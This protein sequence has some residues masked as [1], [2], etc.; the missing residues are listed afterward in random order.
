[1]DLQVAPGVFS[2]GVDAPD[3]KFF[4]NQYLLPHGMSYNSYVVVAG[5]IAVMDSV[6]A[7]QGDRWMSRIEEAVGERCP[8][9]LVV[10]HMEPDHS[11]CILEAMRRWPEM[12]VVATAKAIAMM[13]QFFPDAASDMTSRCL[14][15]KEGDTLDLDGCTLRF[16]LA[17]MVHWPEVMVTY[18]ETH[19]ILFSADAFG[20]FG[21]LEHTDNWIDEARR[22]Y[23]NIVNKYGAQV[24][25]VLKKLSP[26]AIDTIAPLH[27]PVLKGD[28]TPYLNLYDTWSRYCPETRGVLVAYAS[29]YGGTAGAALRLAEKLREL[30]AG[31]VVVCDLCHCDHSEALAQ[32]FRLTTT[33]LASP[34]YDA[35]LFPPMHDFIYHLTIKNFRNRRVALIENGSW[36]PTAARLMEKM[37][38]TLPGIEYVE[39]RVTIKSVP[40][41]DVFKQID[42][43]AGEIARQ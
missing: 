43:L 26:L 4:E 17:P 22:Y 35:G 37:L 24:Q 28:L 34:T 33:V 32:A 25:S 2:V 9:Y 1:M 15:V 19:R 12:Q 16:F 30:D 21:S 8:D 23:M 42:R 36:A 41:D 31:T 13:K 3:E 40:D 7:G 6:E 27:G 10:Q 14:Q 18:D 38:D 29:I 11:A 39:P 5:R 20:K